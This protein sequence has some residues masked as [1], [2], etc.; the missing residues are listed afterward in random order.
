MSER[1]DLLASIATKVQ[2]YRA[3][4]LAAPD[5]GH[6]DRWAQQFSAHDQVPFLK[7]F[8]HVIGQT[9]LTQQMV[10]Q[11]LQDL[12]VN[13]KLAGKD[14]RSYWR[15][16]NVLNIQ[17]YGQSQKEMLKLFDIALQKQCGFGL[18]GCGSDEGDYIYLDDILFSG[19]RVATDLEAWISEKAPAKANVQVLLMGLHTGGHYFINS[20]RLREAR[21]NANKDIQFHFWR[22]VELENQKYHKD[23]SGVLWPTV[24]PDDPLVKQYVE[25]EKRFP[26]ALR[27]PGGKLNFFSSEVGRQLLEREFLVA[28]VKIRSRIQEPKSI[29]RPL[30]FGNFGVGFGSPI[31]TYRNCPNNA[32]LAVWWGDP[33][34]T[35]GALHWYPLVPRKTYSSP[36]NVFHGLDDLTG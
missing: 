35:S 33:K 6:V 21:E 13:E 19:S 32:P 31:A 18:A 24:I 15:K 9:F 11:F 14:F 27:N 20:R 10:D 34:A 22:M 12:V 16:A 7:E 3:G 26:L 1:D 2:T 23:N 4:E 17:K 28:G 5:A 30:G 36:E 29:M 8:D 25:S